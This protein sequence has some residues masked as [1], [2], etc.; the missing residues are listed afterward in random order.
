MQIT[1]AW[2]RH[3]RQ[4]VGVRLEQIRLT[5]F[6]TNSAILEAEEGE[7]GHHAL[8]ASVSRDT[9]DSFTDPRRGMRL[10]LGAELLSERWGSYADVYRLDAGISK[11][12][13]VLGD[14]AF[15]LDARLALA[16][17]ISDRPVAIFDRYFAGG[18]STLRGFRYREVGPE[19]NRYPLGGKSRFLGT[20]EFRKP[21]VAR[22]IIGRVFCDFGNVWADTAGW[23]PEE[24]NAS[25]GFGV[26]F[27]MPIGPLV[28]DYGYPIER[29]QDHLD[30]GGRL[31]FTIGYTF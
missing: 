6:S 25:I 14:S 16:D 22:T 18:A 10:D 12:F 1:R 2:L 19:D 23:D 13:P 5:D 7:Y 4:S 24:L 27:R 8:T 9:R 11:Y 26:E 28:L 29:Q 20:A 17:S 15:K 30:S 3:W 31:H 21:L